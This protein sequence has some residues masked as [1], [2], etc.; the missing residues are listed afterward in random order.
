M[1]RGNFLLFSCSLFVGCS[2]TPP[3]QQ[4]APA[5]TFDIGMV[6]FAGYA[7]LYLAKEKGYFGDLDVR[8]H[9]IEEVPAIRAAVVRGDLEAYLATPD[10][11]QDTND[12]P[13]GKAV[14]ALDES[15]GGDGVVVGPGI[16]DVQQLKGKTIAAEPGLPP[17]F[18]LMYVLHKNGMALSD[19]SFKDM[20]T[21]NA[22]TAFIAGSLDGAGIYEPYL[23]QAKASRAGSSI[24]LSSADTPG[25]IVDLMFVN[26]ATAAKR[27]EDVR[28]VIAGWRK[29]VAF[30]R[31]DPDEAF[32]IM[33]TAFGLPNQ[34]FADIV[35]GITW[36][37][38]ADNRRLFGSATEPGQ[39]RVAFDTVNSVLRRNRPSV[40]AST[41][42]E[43]L[44]RDFIPIE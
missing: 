25:M 4:Q 41:A 42:D 38:L 2:V 19:V 11:A 9:R 26:D 8:L 40:Y 20:T 3:Q 14:W 31:T 21:Q 22:S 17:Y 18:V 43:Y 34:E 13:P 30:I 37:D 6:S 32:K 27:P 10:I 39:L 23:S 28:K 5:E 33:S 12:R 16:T 29:A 15:K 44:V 36:L 7:P 24:V 35:G 1:N